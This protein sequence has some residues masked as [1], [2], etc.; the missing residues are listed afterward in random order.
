M[1]LEQ[2]I[3]HRPSLSCHFTP[4][5]NVPFFRRALSFPDQIPLYMW[6]PLLRA[7]YPSP[8]WKPYSSYEIQCSREDRGRLC[9]QVRQTCIS[10]PAFL[11]IT[12][13]IWGKL[14][15]P[16]KQKF[17]SWKIQT[18]LV[19]S[20]AG[21]IWVIDWIPCKVPNSVPITLFSACY[22]LLV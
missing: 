4:H 12:C 21:L 14:L 5:C 1:L 18:V 13:E 19:P 20:Q 6:V 8:S 7:F 22:K 11:L 10:I 3:L 16:W 15:N 17:L 9:S 2:C